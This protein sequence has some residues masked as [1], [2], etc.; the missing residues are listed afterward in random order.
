[1]GFSE[2]VV[3]IVNSIPKGKVVTYGDISEFLSGNKQSSQSVGQVIK[4]QFE[5]STDSFPW[6]RV[7]SKDL[8]PVELEDLGID[9]QARAR[10]E[11]EVVS[12]NNGAVNNKHLHKLKKCQTPN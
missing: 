3:K 6:W 1:M 10:L 12:F 4:K 11:K 5:L 2:K 8:T 7:V 9:F